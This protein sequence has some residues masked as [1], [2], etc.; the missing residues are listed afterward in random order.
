LHGIEVWLRQKGSSLT[1]KSGIG[2]L[3]DIPRRKKRN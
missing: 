1:K 2:I 3:L